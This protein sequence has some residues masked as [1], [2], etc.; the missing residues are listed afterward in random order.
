[1]NESK[2]KNYYSLIKLLEN[3]KGVTIEQIQEKLLISRKSVYR[4]FEEIRKNK[5]VITSKMI[6]HSHQ[7]SFFI[8]LNET[9]NIPILNNEQQELLQILAEYG[10]SVPPLTKPTQELENTLSY[11]ELIPPFKQEFIQINNFLPKE[12]RGDLTTKTI[13]EIIKSIKN[14]RVANINYSKNSSTTAIDYKIVPIKLFINNEGFYLNAYKINDLKKGLRTFAL[15][16]INSYEYLEEAGRIPKRIKE[17]SNNQINDMF[18]VFQEKNLIT[19]KLCFSKVIAE[20][21]LECKLPEASIKFK[22]IE[23]DKIILTIKTKGKLELISWIL[24]WRDQVKVI[25]PLSLKNEIKDTIT[26]MLEIYK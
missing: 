12:K 26:K 2:L 24:S 4:L 3:K 22:Y 8:V 13:F 11:L 6:A 20:Y 16:R 10:K 25:G 9:E 21:I 18:G 19:A 17:E 7:K 14:H 5:I 1:M 15:E 23:D